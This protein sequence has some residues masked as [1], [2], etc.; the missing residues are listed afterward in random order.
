MSLLL[1]FRPSEGAASPVLPGAVV[2]IRVALPDPRI[3]TTVP[4]AQ[5]RVALPDTRIRVPVVD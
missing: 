4:T 2:Y 1:L 5:V 3:R